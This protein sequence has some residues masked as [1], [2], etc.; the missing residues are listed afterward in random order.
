V[1][2]CGSRAGAD[3]DSRL[4]QRPIA[5]GR[6]GPRWRIP[7]GLSE[8]G[9]VEGQNVTVEYHWLEG[10][11]AGLKSVLDDDLMRPT[12]LRRGR[13]IMVWQTRVLMDDGTLIAVAIQ[14]QMVL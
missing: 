11:Y 2:A 12:P 8:T 3:A 10:K 13:R 5:R 6:A 7:Q 4:S 9:Y 14:T 1:V